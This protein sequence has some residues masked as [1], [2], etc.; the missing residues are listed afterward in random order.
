MAV[1]PDLAPRPPTTQD[2]QSIWLIT[3]GDMVTLL[4]T[5][6]VMLYGLT[7]VERSG[8]ADDGGSR[9]DQMVQALSTRFGGRVLIVDSGGHSGESIVQLKEGSQL[10]D[11]LARDL[12]KAGV[13]GGRGKV[14]RISGGLRVTLPGELLFDFASTDLKPQAVETIRVIADTINTNPGY[15]V[16]L[17]GHTDDVPVRSAS[18]KF[19][20][21][22]EL[23]CLRALSVARYFVDECGVDPKRM[24][25]SGMG[26]W[27]PV[28]PNVSESGR[29][30]NRRV[31]ILL[32]QKGFQEGIRPFLEGTQAAPATG[33]PEAPP[34]GPATAPAEPP[35]PPGPVT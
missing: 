13:D 5:F 25:A 32:V 34:G 26:E 9:F 30:Q 31:E 3:Y 19:E 29:R 11:S 27:H 33:Q 28:T 24:L 35:L 20:D 17:L 22:F 15:D 12:A 16:L 21:N 23:S 6:F 18:G 1:Q 14:E 10:V 8:P 4:L 2:V 7:L